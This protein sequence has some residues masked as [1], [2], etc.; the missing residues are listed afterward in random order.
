ML[1]FLRRWAIEFCL[2]YYFFQFGLGAASKFGLQFRKT[3]KKGEKINYDWP[4]FNSRP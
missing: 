1:K 3:Y 2:I 4:T